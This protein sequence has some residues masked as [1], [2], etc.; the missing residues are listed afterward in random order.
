MH[1]AKRAAPGLWFYCNVRF[2]F[3]LSKR[4]DVHD[5][6]GFPTDWRIEGTNPAL[7]EGLSFHFAAE[8]LFAALETPVASA[9]GKSCARIFRSY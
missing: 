6:R 9:R 1:V 3:Q 8:E 7:A 4:G 2:P 5:T